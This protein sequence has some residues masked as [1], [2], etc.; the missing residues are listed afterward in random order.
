MAK[1]EG[2]ASAATIATN[3][4]DERIT[5]QYGIDMGDS[6]ESG[7]DVPRGSGLR[8]VADLSPGG[9]VRANPVH[10]DAASAASA[11][12]AR[13]PWQLPEAPARHR[14]RCRARPPSTS[15]AGS[16]SEERRAGKTWSTES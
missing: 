15:T 1:A 5:G 14:R 13:R 16:R 10:R 12:A 4:Q 9:A 11:S 3:R 7:L 2:L 8:G 6:M